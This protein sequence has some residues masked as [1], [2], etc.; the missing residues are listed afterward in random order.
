MQ[1]ASVL[2]CAEGLSKTYGGVVALDDVDVDFRAG[3]IHALLGENGAGKSTLV[4][5]LTGVVAAS[6][7]EVSGPAHESGDVAMVFQELSVVPELSVLDNLVLAARSKGFLVPYA[8]I[9]GRAK[10]VL[11]TAGLGNI[12]L[13]R[14]VETMSLAQQQLLEIARGLI[15]RAKVLILD[16]PTATLS[17]VEIQRVHEVVRRMAETG[18]AIVYITHRLAEVFQVADYVTIMRAGQVAAAGPTGMFQMND[19]VSH[20]LGGEH[21]AP[22]KVLG[23]D[24]VV[25]DEEVLA[26][27]EL[28]L[29]GKFNKISFSGYSGRVLALFG[30]VGSGADDVIRALAGLCPPDSGGVTLYGSRLPLRSR[31]GTK[32]RGVAY[33]PADR[34]TEGLFLNASVTTNLTSSAL[35]RVSSRWILRRKQELGVAEE[36]AAKVRFDPRR[37][38][39]NAQSFSGGNQQKIAVA[40]ALAARPQLLLMSEPTRGVDIGA[41]SEIYNSLRQLAGEGMT[42]LIYTS[43]IVEIRDLA[44]DVMTLYRGVV[45][46]THSVDE[47]DDSTL[48]SEILRGTAA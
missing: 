2:L 43:D 36:E 40:R 1:G 37:L 12:P 42:V 8:R 39:E 16:E 31:A 47:V 15:R 14:P 46:G 21:N 44:D 48:I 23:R 11:T 6:K 18:C 17:D 27:S 10:E 26:V 25:D 33:V 5:I 30:Q 41:R 4:K 3:Q 7:G 22:T 9:R 24:R 28:T 13:D 32:R 38:S 35:G 19:V 20:M 45:V 34:A 29:L